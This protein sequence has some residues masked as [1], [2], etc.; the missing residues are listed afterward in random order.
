MQSSFA[1][2]LRAC[3]YWPN[4]AVASFLVYLDGSLKAKAALIGGVGQ[5]SIEGCLPQYSHSL[6]MRGAQ[7]ATPRAMSA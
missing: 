1:E 6:R 3:L 5:A 7:S 4:G 2:S